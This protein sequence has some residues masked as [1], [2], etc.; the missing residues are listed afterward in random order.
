MEAADEI[1]EAVVATAGESMAVW[2][3]FA[4]D[5]VAAIA[6]V[7]MFLVGTQTPSLLRRV[8]RG[9]LLGLPVSEEEDD[10]G[11]TFFLRVAGIYKIITTQ[12]SVCGRLL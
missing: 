11:T 2:T 8:P 9:H 6:T 10:L 7:S 12:D 4:A 3:R 5:D 1:S